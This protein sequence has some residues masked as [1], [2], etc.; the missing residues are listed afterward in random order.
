MPIL[1]KTSFSRR[2]SSIVWDL[3]LLAVSSSRNKINLPPKVLTSHWRSKCAIEKARESLSLSKLECKLNPDELKSALSECHPWRDCPT[4]QQRADFLYS[5]SN[6]CNN[7]LIILTL[8]MS[9]WTWLQ[10]TQV[11]RIK[12]NS[13]RQSHL[14]TRFG[15]CWSAAHR[16][17]IIESYFCDA[18]YVVLSSADRFLLMTGFDFHQSRKSSASS[19][20]FSCAS[21]DTCKM[22][23]SVFCLSLRRV[24]RLGWI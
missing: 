22:R 24:K 6:K 20:R 12:N 17:H 19:L 11:A 9:A 23:L 16:L 4:T 5:Q 13:W 7:W 3:I 15:R 14:L 21:S 18:A 8:I 1:E 2:Y 10:Q